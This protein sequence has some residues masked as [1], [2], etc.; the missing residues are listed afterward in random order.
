VDNGKTSIRT[1]H[2]VFKAL[3]YTFIR[4]MLWDGMVFYFYVTKALISIEIHT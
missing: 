2:I 4:I 1:K 3:F